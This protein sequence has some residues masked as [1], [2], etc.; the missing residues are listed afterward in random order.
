MQDKTDK[1]KINR[2]SAVQPSMIISPTNDCHDTGDSKADL[3][4]TNAMRKS[5]ES[6]LHSS[7]MN[8]SLLLR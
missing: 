6:V 4:R 2:I 1:K 7:F 5:I 8:N 3:E